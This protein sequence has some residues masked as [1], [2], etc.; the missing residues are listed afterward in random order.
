VK[1]RS[2]RVVTTPAAAEEGPFFTP[3]VIQLPVSPPPVEEPEPVE[4]AA[5]EVAPEVAEE[6]EQEQA[7]ARKRGQRVPI[8]S[9]D[10]VLLGVRRNEE[11]NRRSG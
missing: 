1:P 5:T 3:A 9:W 6:T 10:D 2:P 11:E 4:E 7:P 8:P